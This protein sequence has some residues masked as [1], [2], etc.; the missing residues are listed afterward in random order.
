MTSPAT[1][2]SDRRG[3]DARRDGCL[4]EGGALEQLAQL[5]RRRV[6]VDLLDRPARSIGIEPPDLTEPSTGHRPARE[7]AT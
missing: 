5:V 6:V 2:P 4:L 1:V 7:A 3:G